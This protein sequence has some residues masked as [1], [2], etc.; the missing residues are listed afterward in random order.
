ML[1]KIVRKADVHEAMQYLRAS[2]TAKE[3]EEFL[4][5]GTT[6]LSTQLGRVLYLTHN[7]WDCSICLKH[8]DWLMRRSPTRFVLV[9][10]KEMEESYAFLPPDFAGDSSC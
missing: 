8:G 7:F 10:Q 9:T 6:I 2:T 1:V 5:D 3:L 4:P